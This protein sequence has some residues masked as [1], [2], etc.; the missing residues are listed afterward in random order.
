LIRRTAAVLRAAATITLNALRLSAPTA[1]ALTAIA[2]GSQHT[3][4]DAA[5]WLDAS[6]LP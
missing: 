5:R 2:L 6:P 1:A 3:I 4:A